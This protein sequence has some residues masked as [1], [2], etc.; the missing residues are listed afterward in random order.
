VAI[1]LAVVVMLVSGVKPQHTISRKDVVSAAVVEVDKRNL[2]KMPDTN[3]TTTIWVRLNKRAT[4]GFEKYSR[5]QLDQD[6]HIVHGANNVADIALYYVFTNEQAGEL[7]LDLFFTN[8]DEA[9][10]AYAGLLEK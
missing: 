4:V 5:D 6:I 8:Y 2:S 1:T 10:K 9:T 7:E 3:I